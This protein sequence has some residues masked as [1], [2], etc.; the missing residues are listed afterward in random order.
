MTLQQITY[1][2]VLESI[3]VKQENFPYRYK[4]EEFYKNFELLSPAFVEGR[5]DLMTPDQ[6]LSKEWKN[7]TEEIIKRVFAPL[8]LVQYQEFSR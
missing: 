3:R 6:R 4:Y 5:Y 2:G 8:D 1:M 7:L